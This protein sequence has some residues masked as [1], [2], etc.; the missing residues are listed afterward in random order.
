MPAAFTGMLSR[1]ISLTLDSAIYKALFTMTMCTALYYTF[2]IWTT[3][4]SPNLSGQD[5]P[6]YL[7]FFFESK[8]NLKKVG[9]KVHKSGQILEIK[10]TFCSFCPL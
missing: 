1:D 7:R 9:Q 3:L 8:Q 4:L 2:I 10:L 5:R 6:C